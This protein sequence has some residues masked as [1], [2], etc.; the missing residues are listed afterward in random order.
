MRAEGQAG[1]CPQCAAEVEM[2]P[3]EGVEVI[4]NLAPTEVEDWLESEAI[5]PSQAADGSSL[6][7]LNSQ[8]LWGKRI[9]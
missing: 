1:W 3:I 9:S 7:C 2:I 8:L 4:S 5:H 6:I